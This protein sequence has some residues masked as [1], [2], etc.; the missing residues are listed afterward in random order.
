MQTVVSSV[1]KAKKNTASDSIESSTSNSSTVADVPTKSKS[2]RIAA[3]AVTTIVEPE[4]LFDNSE[5]D[6]HDY[7]P[8]DSSDEETD[9]ESDVEDDYSLVEDDIDDAS[10]G[11]TPEELKIELKKML[12]SLAKEIALSAVTVFYSCLLRLRSLTYLLF[13]SYFL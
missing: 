13:K 4:I 2:S 9:L 11:L 3:T 6:E 5:D 12:P 7:Q 8:S 10:H 1:K